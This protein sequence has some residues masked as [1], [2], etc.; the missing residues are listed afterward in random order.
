MTWFIPK[1]L[2]F[3]A[4]QWP[5][6]G[7]AGLS[8]FAGEDRVIQAKDGAVYVIVSSGHPQ[9]LEPGWWVRRYPDGWIAASDGSCREDWEE[10][11]APQQ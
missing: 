10:T 2:P 9:R 1:P 3:E 4:K 6:V 5:V 11:K 7:L 8:R